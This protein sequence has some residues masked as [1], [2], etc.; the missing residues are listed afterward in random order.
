MWWFEVRVRLG[1]RRQRKLPRGGCLGRGTIWRIGNAGEQRTK[2]GSGVVRARKARGERCTWRRPI[3]CCRRGHTRCRSGIGVLVVVGMEEIGIVRGS[4]DRGE[5]LVLVLRGVSWQA[6]SRKWKWRRRV[7]SLHIASDGE[8]GLEE[9]AGGEEEDERVLL[10]APTRACRAT[11]AGLWPSLA[12]L[13]T[14]RATCHGRVAQGLRLQHQTTASR[15]NPLYSALYLVSGPR[16]V[17]PFIP[18]HG[19]PQD[20]WICG[21]LISCAEI[22]PQP[23]VLIGVKGPFV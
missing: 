17:F 1:V 13:T 22:W 12:S 19:L 18:W 8:H 11:R 6:E 2:T 3:K 9:D 16:L 23:S 14:T 15:L 21:G 20:S 7:N 5:G 10:A 4:C